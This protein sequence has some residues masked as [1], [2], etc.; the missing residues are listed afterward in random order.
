[1]TVTRET[2]TFADLQAL[3]AAAAAEIVAIAKRAIDQRG[4]F[5]LALA[6]GSTPKRTYEILA[7][8]RRDDIDWTRTTIVFGDERYVPPDDPLSNYKMAREALID[9]VPIPAANVH[10]VQTALRSPLEAAERYER[11]LRGALGGDGRHAQGQTVDIALLGVGTDGHT[12]SLFPDTPE[13]TERVRWV[14]GVKAPTHGVQPVVPRVSATLAFL[15][16]ARATIFL[17]SG[18]DKRAIVG[19]ILDDTPTGRRYPAAMVMP[20]PPARC[21]WMLDRSATPDRPNT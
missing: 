12:A 13:L 15:N 5:T 17:V 7:T 21:L 19:D 18:A 16:A 2:R 20:H 14:V 11:T 4:R 8:R 10:A 3:S 9:R 1:M 6:G